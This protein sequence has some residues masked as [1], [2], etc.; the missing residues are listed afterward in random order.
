MVTTVMMI[1][2]NDDNENSDGG[3]GD[4]DIGDYDDGGDGDSDFGDC[5]HSGDGGSDHRDDSSD[6][7]FLETYPRKLSKS[8]DMVHGSYQAIRNSCVDCFL[9]IKL[10]FEI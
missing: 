6:A 1:M 3:D 9:M 8:L 2:V 5:D 7:M 4:S 10:W